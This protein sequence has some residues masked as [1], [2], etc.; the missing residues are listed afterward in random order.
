MCGEEVPLTEPRGTLGGSHK[1]LCGG[2]PV[3]SEHADNIIAGLQ[4]TAAIQGL[5]DVR[6]KL[7]EMV[8]HIDILMG[9]DTRT[10]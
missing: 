6:K 7:A 9:E 3:A 5:I 4:R 1:L 10:R 8:E 2:P